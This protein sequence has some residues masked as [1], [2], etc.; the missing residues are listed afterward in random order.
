LGVAL[1][2]GG[3]FVLPQVTDTS[4]TRPG[5]DGALAD[6]GAG[7]AT[8]AEARAHSRAVGKVLAGQ[9]CQA[10]HQLPDPA[11]LDARTWRDAVL[12]TM[13]PR[14][15]IFRHGPV[16]YSRHKYDWGLGFE[17]F[18]TSPLLSEAQWQSVIDYY[19]TSAPAVL[20]AQARPR[21]VEM[22]LPL[23]RVETPTTSSGAPFTCLVKVREGGGP[24]SLAVSD[25]ESGRTQFLDRDLNVV[26]TA[27][28]A[29]PVLDARI[30][31]DGGVVLCD[32][33]EMTPNNGTAG[34]A[35]RFAPGTDGRLAREPV[36][37]FDGLRRPVQV[38]PADLDGDGDEDYLVCEFGSLLGGLAW[39][40]QT[41]PGTFEKHAL[42]VLPGAVAARVHDHNRDGKPDVWALFSQGQEGVFLYTNRGGGKFRQ[43]QVLSF[44]PTYGSSHFELAD[45]NGDGHADVV[46]TAGD[47]GDQ[48][49]I[50]KPYHGVYLFLNDGANRFAQRYFFPIHGCYRALARDFD[51]DG[52]LDLATIACFADDPGQPEEA[53]VYLENVGG[54]D[55]RP[56]SLEATKHGRWM[57]MDAGDLD[58]DGDLDLVL[59][60]F[61]LPMPA[62]P[63]FDW[64]HAPPFLVLRNL[65]GGRTD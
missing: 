33:G 57:N 20:P 41:A 52:D 62:R 58:A 42:S 8:E 19:V 10:C 14:L 39:M 9:Y 44:P 55:F 5:G 59:A 22:G 15:G 6:V 29:G 56:R 23:F 24:W 49:P 54:L 64:Q 51:A 47:N 2:L 65:G 34:V 43:E 31:A 32:A 50:L 30:D 38:S 17:F 27:R 16:D 25:A 28:T 12:P 53:F 40:E 13:G 45:F 35:L 26:D 18:P 61:A 63:N 11:L 60:N 46:Y 7:G 36:R 1:F 4:G 21:P 3:L 37:L 48:S